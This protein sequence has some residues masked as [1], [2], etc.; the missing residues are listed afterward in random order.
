MCS[1]GGKKSVTNPE[2]VLP[3]ESRS[4]QTHIS[5][6]TIYSILTLQAFLFVF[7]ERDREG[8]FCFQMRL[9]QK[10]RRLCL[11]L[12]FICHLSTCLSA[13][14]IM[15]TGICTSQLEQEKFSEPREKGEVHRFR[16]HQK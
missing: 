16:K 2:H 4:C 8:C 11:G 7:T 1:K 10:S 9:E 5:N 3:A 6:L 13:V 15:P 12:L 14:M